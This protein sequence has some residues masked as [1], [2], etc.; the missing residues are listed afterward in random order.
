MWTCAPAPD[1]VA[2]FHAALPGY[3][4]T[5]LTELPPLAAEL[6]VG[7]VFVKD[8]SHRLG[9]PAF[10]A[11][12]ASWAVHR[13]V[14]AHRGGAPLTLVTAT[15]GNHGRAVARFARLAGQRAHILVPR[16]VHPDAR[17][18]I[19]A[20]GARVTRV[21]GDYDDAVRRA[22]AARGTPGTVLVQD[23]GW[24]GYEEIP[25]W[26]VE[27]YATLFAETAA[28]LAAAGAGPP[29]LVAVP[30]GVG[31]LAQA[32]VVH[33]RGHPGTRA[34]LLAV[35]PVGA[36]CVGASLAAGHPVSVPCGATTMTGL[37]AGTPSRTAWPHLLAGLDTAVAVADAESARAAR[38]LAALGVSAGPC[39]A[40]SLAGA[41]AALTGPH[42]PTRRA[43]LDVGP[44]ATVL[45]LST[46]GAEA[47]PS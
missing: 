14:E 39:G 17:A 7:R 21:D 30:T 8:E 24:P 6:G 11:L 35:E 5:P 42:A 28:Q 1:G 29:G 10:K 32:A 12:G 18:A 23:V 25:G 33:H 26:V 20:E 40:A 44:G 2:A 34:A 16:G 37:C 41:R 4:P 27:G 9:L 15:D 43:D 3:A 22:A 13:I 36:A 38:D 31:S 45:L 19:A 46:E 47:N